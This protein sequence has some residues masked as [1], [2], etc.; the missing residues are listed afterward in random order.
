MT[1]RSH[2]DTFRRLVVSSALAGSLFAFA[3][4]A[5]GQTLPGPGSVVSTIPNGGGNSPQVSNPDANTLL[6][7]LRANNTVI[8]WNGFNVPAGDTANFTD[9][10]GGASNPIAVLNRD[11][12]GSSN[13]SQ[14]LGSL[15]SDNNVAVW[16]YNPNGILVGNNAVINVGGL[17]LTTL[18][19]DNPA[20]FN[21][22]GSY[23]LATTAGSTAKIQVGAG[24]TITTTASVANRAGLVLVAPQIDAAGATGTTFDGGNSEVAFV[25]ATDVQLQYD[26]GS[27]LGVTINKGT[28]FNGTSIV[29]GTIS[30]R[31]VFFAI[32]SQ[33]TITDALLQVDADATAAVTSNRGIVLLG[34]QTSVTGSGVTVA[35]GAGTDTSGVA[36]V[37]ANGALVSGNKVAAAATGDVTIA[38]A[39]TAETNYAATG[40][41]VTLGS[42]ATALQQAK[43]TATITATNGDI[44][45][46][47]GLTLRSNSDDDTGLGA[48]A[49]TLDVTGGD[50]AFAA[51]SALQ[52]GSNK[53]SDVKVDADVIGSGLSLGDVTARNLTSAIGGGLPGNVHRTGTIT[54]GNLNLNGSVTVVSDTGNVS[55]G[56]ITLTGGGAD[57]TL[58]ATAGDVT[59]AGAVD[60]ADDYLVTG[61]NVTL[62]DAGGAP[63]LQQARGVVTITAANG[64]ITG[65]DG[66]TLRSNSDNDTGLGAETLTLDV[67]GGDIAFAAGSA[68]QGGSNKQSDVKVNADVIGSGLALGDITA[69]NLVNAIGGVTTSPIVRTGTVTLGN[70]DLTGSLAVTSNTGDVSVGSIAVTGSAASI[71]LISTAGGITSPALANLTADG[72][73]E[74]QAATPLTIGGATSTSGHVTVTGGADVTTGAL[75][76]GTFATVNATG[77][78]QIGGLSTGAGNAQ[79]TAGGPATINGTVNVVG[80]YLVTGAGVSLGGTQSASGAVTIESTGGGNLSALPGLALTAN[81]DGVGTELLSLK[82]GGGL[83]LGGSTLTNLAGTVRFITP[84]DATAFVVGNVNAL[85]LSQQIGALAPVDGTITRTGAITFGDVTTGSAITLNSGGALITGAI[86]SPGAIALTGTT[87]DAVSATSVAGPVNVTATTGDLAIGTVGS[88]GAATLSTTGATGDIRV[89]NATAAGTLTVSSVGGVRGRSGARANLSSTGGDLTVTASNTAT[90]TLGTASAA[91]NLSV[92]AGTIDVSTPT[93][94][95]GSLTLSAVTGSLTVGAISA[96]TGVTLNTN[97]DLIV[98]SATSSAGNVS[99]TSAA[100]NTT[101]G[102][103]T[104]ATSV[105]VSAAG[106]ATVTGNVTAG[107]T[108]DVTGASVNLGVDPGI[109]L[110]QAAGAVTITANTGLITGGTGLTLLGN[111]DDVGGE[112]VRFNLAPA[113]IDF[114]AATIK[115]GANRTS[116]IFFGYTNTAT[117]ITLGDVSGSTFGAFNGTTTFGNYLGGMT[118]NLVTGDLDFS[119]FTA[120]STGTITIGALNGVGISLSASGSV[121]L[122]GPVT[123]TGGFSLSSST[124]NATLL[125]NV[126]ASDVSIGA[127]GAVTGQNITSTANSIVIAGSSVAFGDLDAKTFVNATATSGN[128]TLNSAKAVTTLTLAG[129]TGV[130]VPT[131]NAG[132]TIN[133]S[134]SGGPVT[135]AGDVTAGG[136]YIVSGTSVNL[137]V[138]PGA[139]LQ[140][141]AG[142]VTI[143]ASSGLI[144]GGA[145][146]TLLGNSDNAGAEDV[147]FNLSPVGIDFSGATIQGGTAKSSRIFFGTSVDTTPVTLGNVTAASF[148]STSNPGQL[149]LQ[150][151][152]ITVGNLDMTS[153]TIVGASVTTG[154]LSGGGGLFGFGAYTGGVA[155]NGPVNI[156]S[157]LLVQT[158]AG[159][160]TFGGPVTAAAIEAGTI[161]TP[162]PVTG[163]SFTA[164]TGDISITGSS[165]TTGDLNATGAIALAGLTS[166]VTAT[167]ATAGGNFTVTS[168]GAVT[169]AGDVT[170]GGNYKVTGATVALGVDGDAETQK[171]AGN[172]DITSSTGAITGGAGLTLQSNSDGVGAEY[173]VLDS[174]SDITFAPTSTLLGGT[175]SQSNLGVR[176]S[177]AGGALTLGSVTALGLTGVDAGRA[178]FG[179]L[180]VP[181]DVTATGPLTLVNALDLVST[182]GAISFTSLSTSGAGQGISLK[183]SGTKTIGVGTLTGT[184]AVVVNAGGAVTA[185]TVS[186]SNV[187]VTGASVDLT[188]AT[189]TGAINLTSTNGDI[190]LGSGNAGTSATLTA[191]H[192]ISFATTLTAGTDAT[193]TAGTDITGDTLNA[194]NVFTANAGGTVSIA[195]TTANGVGVIASE[196]NLPATNVTGSL[197]LTSTVGGITLG[198]GSAGTTAN[199]NAATTLDITAPFTSG[200]TMTLVANGAATVGTLASTGGAISLTAGSVSADAIDAATTLLVKTNAGDAAVS[201]QLKAGGLLTVNTTGNATLATVES[202]GGDVAI[203][204]GGTLDAD[205]LKS[206]IGAVGVTSGGGVTIAAVDAGTSLSL[207][208]TGSSLSVDT[209]NAGTTA[210]LDAAGP[211]SVTTGLTA[212]GDVSATA[213]SAVQAA[214]IKSTGGGVT[215]SGASA[216]LTEADAANLLKVTTTGGMLQ[217]GQA[218]AGSASLAATGPLSVTGFVHTTGDA[219]ATATGAATL[220][221]IE[222]SGGATS[223][224]GSTV[225]VATAKALNSLTITSTTGQLTLGTGTAGT[226]TLTSAG[227][228]AITSLTTSG[229]TN[230]TAAGAVTGGLIKS[231]GGAVTIGGLSTDLT[232]ADASGLLKVT[233]SNGQLRLGQATA[234][235]ATLAATGPLIVTGFVHT[236]GDAS[237]TATG[238]ATIAD[239]ES[240]AGAIAVTGA[241]TDVTT[242]SA[243][244][245]LKIISTTGQLTLGTGTAGTAT[246]T[247]AGDAAITSLTT[248]G[249]A[250]VTAAGAV[251][252]GLI[253][254]TGGAV[255]IS[256][257]SADLTEADAAST[258]TV[259]TTGGQLRI[260]QATAG[261]ASLTA[262]GPLTVTGFVHTTGNASATATGAATITD[263]QSSGGAVSI[264]GATVDAGTVGAATALALTATAGN[265]SLGAQTAGTTLTLTATGDVRASGALASGGDAI[266]DAGGDAQLASVTATNGS[267]TVTAGGAVTGSGGGRAD[268]TA[269]GAGHGV[270]VTAGTQAL[271][272]NVTAAGDVNVSAATIDA[273][274]ARSTGG[275]LTLGATGGALTVGTAASGTTATLNSAGTL[276]VA[277]LQSGGATTATATGA[278]T[279]GTTTTGGDLKI[280]AAAITA[281]ATSVTGA[282][283]FTS[284]GD[285]ALS[286]GNVSGA[287]I[288]DT[289]GRA[290]LGAVTAGPSITVKATDAALGGALKAGAVNLI[291]RGTGTLRLGDG[292]GSDGFQLSANEVNL[293]DADKLTIDGGTGPVAIGALAFGAN[294]GRTNVDVLTTGAISVTDTVSGSGSTRTFRFGGTAADDTAQASEI[295]IV[296]TADGGGRLLFAGAGLDLRGGKIVLGQSLFVDTVMGATPESV[297][298]I[299]VSNPNSSLYNAALSGGPYNPANQTLLSAN[300]LS[301]RYTSFA[302]FQN[303]GLAGTNAG[304]VL[305]G[306][307]A[308][309]VSGALALKG[310]GTS[311]PNS[312]ALFGTINGVEGTATALLGNTVITVNGVNLPNSR[313][314]G[315]II[316]SGAGCLTTTI[317]QPSLNVFDS[318]RLDIFRSADDFSLPFDPVVGSNNEAL[319]AGISAIDVPASKDPDDKSDSPPPEEK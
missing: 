158:L 106:T 174:A 252:G 35:T 80:D 96:P 176:F 135:L 73:I 97:G 310:P 178:T 256:A 61:N 10:T 270:K 39:V 155:I 64:N 11:I 5:R 154:A 83:A 297:P 209:A 60:V 221:D 38:G 251:T 294:A 51:G 225:D 281:G 4:G 137:G 23:N 194:G 188:T 193:L 244:G 86:T 148:G 173:L 139:E 37:T 2:R 242:A 116:R 239:I 286:Q 141:A 144:T 54:L 42:G 240:S 280:T 147:T 237:A 182:A 12:N 22:S 125:G 132:G 105:L 235:T 90:A 88:G 285:L 74:L 204:T 118:G 126:S 81:S 166:D 181:G 289:T 303:A 77:L 78:A 171:A 30:G 122:N 18:D 254:S 8:N 41:S 292:T 317:S 258:L 314:N 288:L 31:N 84:T 275:A 191:S 308:T 282:L 130:T 136:D 65:R 305:G 151:A 231:T 306:T 187:A 29:A 131:L 103:I 199:F 307:T 121:T 28:A 296:A 161:G 52:G 14:I 33:S 273:T 134:S 110:Q 156:S 20:N 149:V 63:T 255:T 123:E 219:S 19:I 298:G 224:A 228:A 57:A 9:N 260:G 150:N 163:G 312:F 243:S 195:H 142:A 145:G 290:T 95:A 186:G 87:V 16:V 128:L 59:V 232:E 300:T 315:C 76:A 117:P 293:I 32:A 1:H 13:I 175:A 113:G 44:T 246:L 104:A 277:T 229:A 248:G 192:A 287:A 217:I 143:T 115:G 279:L 190:I 262:A 93:A 218:T 180:V 127:A 109:E 25:A 197:S 318:S 75:D 55:T 172:V 220:A 233:A 67:T 179:Q 210:T 263:I 249:A 47:A 82:T 302:L 146:L 264:T 46:N 152:P 177:G 99:L 119:G 230:I 89:D 238:A 43:G 207:K 185:T 301:V 91:N 160:I 107:T 159:G 26:F 100:G 223:V 120:V 140:Q 319:F 71:K 213:T 58:T 291:N 183:T 304:V 164:T 102:D 62:G 24:A 36:G 236:T 272:G 214:S 138:D 92:T 170:A 198:G 114:S 184:G 129:S 94:T 66:L 69:R 247:S 34:G 241:T 253:K 202:T 268:L 72:D 6:V 222:S 133:V 49:L 203:T 216:D 27:P 234:G 284:T 205:S 259:T 157:Q 7:R 168:T 206:D 283:N 70:V 48:E 265:L 267:V 266:V 313:V 101:V 316:G 215:V 271:L 245:D 111:S 278:A 211:L 85:Q 309:P 212:G 3:G 196:I 40:R 108:Y 276:N 45:G 226:A 227:D 261:S 68:L 274:T 50:I 200:G 17:V 112:D 167:S 124:G 201:G 165:V 269:A 56:G 250:N 21:G 257:S 295:R 189:A 15:T 53:Q 311:T 169:L 98:G 162:A 153:V 208:S 79:V 299:F